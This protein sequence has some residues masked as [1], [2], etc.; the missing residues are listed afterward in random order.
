M[1]KTKLIF[2]ILPIMAALFV[3][4]II[5]LSI[6]IP[7]NDIQNNN[8]LNSNQNFSDSGLSKIIL[9]MSEVA[10]H[11]TLSDCWMVISNKVYDV[12]VF[13]N[14]HPGGKEEIAKGCGINATNLYETKGG[15]GEPHT[16]TTQSF[17]SSFYL[18][19][20]NQ[21]ITSSAIENKIA[22]LKNMTIP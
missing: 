14:S 22:E 2:L 3:A 19:E 7:K 21:E 15:K 5:L 11:N 12:T 16:S 9:T 13:I 17:L 4:Q 20:L 10:K 6:L 1:R 18:G 8:N